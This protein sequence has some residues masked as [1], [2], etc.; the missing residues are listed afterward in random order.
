MGAESQSTLYR[1]FIMGGFIFIS[2]SFLAG[3]VVAFKMAGSTIFV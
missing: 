2:R 3:N 1:I